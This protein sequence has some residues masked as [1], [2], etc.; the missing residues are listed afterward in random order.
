MAAS[1]EALIAL[2]G[3]YH[4]A[5]GSRDRNNRT[6]LHFALSNAGRPAS[7]GAVRLLLELDPS[8]RQQQRRVAPTSCVLAEFSH[9]LRRERGILPTVPV[10]KSVWSTCLMQTQ[11]PLPIFSRLFNRFRNGCKSELLCCHQRQASFSQ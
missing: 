2:T 3:A 5:I 10:F 11:T 9:T 4:D 8:S 6:P 7:P 1:V